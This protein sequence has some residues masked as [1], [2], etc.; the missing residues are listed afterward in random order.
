MHKKKIPLNHNRLLHPFWHCVHAIIKIYQAES[1]RLDFE[2]LFFFFA[3]FV[4]SFDCLK[5]KS[6][7]RAKYQGHK[8]DTL[9]SIWLRS[10]KSRCDAS[11]T[12]V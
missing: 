4:P 7:T 3:S 11:D 1:Y 9:P 2:L 6:D 5:K 8:L 12:L 10:I